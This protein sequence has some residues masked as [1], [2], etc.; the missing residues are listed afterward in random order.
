MSISSRPTA[1]ERIAGNL[2]V[3]GSLPAIAAL[4]GGPLAALLPPLAKTLAAER[5][6]NRVEA[7]LVDI[8]ATLRQH[9]D[10]LSLLTDQQYKFINEAVL[11]LLHTTDEKKIAL[12]KLVVRNGLKMSQMPDHDSVFLTRIVRDIS[13]EEAYFL[14]QNFGKQ[15]IWLNDTPQP[16]AEES[17]LSVGPET[18]DGQIVLGLITLGL[19]TTAEPTW[20]DSGL[21]KYSP[22]VAKLL[23]ILRAEAE[24]L[25]K[26]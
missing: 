8:E 21:L 9:S 13:A 17:T 2:P 18:S 15:R 11:A 4:A 19:V 16:Q 5:Q 23:A 22:I 1:I 25:V 6:R 3:E 12:L 7:A 24:P 10:H 14:M 20:D 26:P